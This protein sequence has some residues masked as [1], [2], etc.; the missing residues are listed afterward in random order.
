MPEFRMYDVLKRVAAV[1]CDIT[2]DITP[3]GSEDSVPPSVLIGLA[4]DQFAELIYISLGAGG[5]IESGYAGAAIA[6]TVVDIHCRSV[7]YETLVDLMQAVLLG[8]SGWSAASVL[9]TDVAQPVALA[10][11][12]AI[13]TTITIEVV[14][15]IQ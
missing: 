14:D 12:N 1:V 7:T 10:D 2:A 4:P 5:S 15:R 13:E 8:I 6:H 3:E 11:G 9:A